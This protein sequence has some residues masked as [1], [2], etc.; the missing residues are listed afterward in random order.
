MQKSPTDFVRKIIYQFE[1]KANKVKLGRIPYETLEEW[2][3]R[4]G[5]SSYFNMYQMVRYGEGGC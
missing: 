3:N 2:L 4:L 1:G 5:V